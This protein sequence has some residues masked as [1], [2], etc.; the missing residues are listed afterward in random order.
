MTNL[1]AIEIINVIREVDT[2]KAI[3]V[4]TVVN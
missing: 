2:H 1:Q 3:H 4:A